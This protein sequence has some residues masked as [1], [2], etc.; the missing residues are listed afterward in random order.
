[1]FIMIQTICKEDVYK[2]NKKLL[3]V[4]LSVVMAFSVSAVAFAEDENW[5]PVKTSGDA[6]EKGD[7]YL[8]LASVRDAYIDYSGSFEY[9]TYYPFSEKTYMDMP[10]KTEQI[11]D[12]INAYAWTWD[13]ETACVTVATGLGDEIETVA[14][15]V[16]FETT[17]QPQV[18]VACEKLATATA[19]VDG[20]ALTA[21]KTF[22][23]PALDPAD[24]PDT[25]V[26]PTDPAEPDAPSDGSL[27]PWDNV[28]HGNSFW[29][30]LI[31]FFHGILYFFAHLFGK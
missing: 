14:A 24:D 7:L 29:G 8:D 16:A 28:D 21:T 3:A 12:C 6:L 2:N 20:T 18:G 23:I 27:C 15:E 13:G 4:L 10:V 26:T 11:W 9:T 17:A 31:R 22:A 30:K 19:T 1:M 25:P 5:V